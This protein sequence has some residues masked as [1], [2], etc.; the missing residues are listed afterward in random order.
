[1]GRSNARHPGS[2]R[3]EAP[4]R[5]SFAF[6]CSS[7]LIDDAAGVLKGAGIGERCALVVKRRTQEVEIPYVPTA[8][9]L[10]AG[11]FTATGRRT[12]GGTRR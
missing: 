5:A 10:P 11:E 1:M 2:Q 12:R 7:N 6:V 9:T 3:A 4:G 8:R